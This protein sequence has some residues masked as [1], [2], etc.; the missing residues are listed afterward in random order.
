LVISVRRAGPES[1]VADDR[2]WQSGAQLLQQSPFLKVRQLLE[3][4]RAVHRNL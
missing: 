4:Y 2:G 1:Q 3:Q